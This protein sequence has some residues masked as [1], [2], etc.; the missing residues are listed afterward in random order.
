M[1]PDELYLFEQY[2]RIEDTD[3]IQHNLKIADFFFF[4]ILFLSM[5]VMIKFYKLTIRC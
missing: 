2:N 1:I 3:N 4:L 5:I